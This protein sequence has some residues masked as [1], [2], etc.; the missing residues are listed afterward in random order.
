MPRLHLTKKDI[1]ASLQKSLFPGDTV[2]LHADTMVLAQLKLGSLEQRMEILL[3]SFLEVLGENGELIVPTFSYSFCNNNS[4]S[5]NETPASSGLGAFSEFV[6]THKL[7]KRSY[8][9]LFSVSIFSNTIDGSLKNVPEYAFGKNSIFDYLY[10]KNS[11]IMCL[12]CSLDRITFTHYLEQKVQVDYRY[13]KEFSGDLITDNN[14]TSKTIKYFVKDLSKKFILDLNIFKSFL[15]KNNKLIHS[16]VGR[17]GAYT[18][19]SHDFVSLGE[20]F[21]KDNP[22]GLIRTM[23]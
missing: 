19:K 6:R 3:Q 7:S 4:F 9:P 2:M 16:S 15:E 10:N 1:V 5:P 22:H 12:G 23:K 17:I 18:I 11:K 21:L 13:I 20:E 14:I 8:D